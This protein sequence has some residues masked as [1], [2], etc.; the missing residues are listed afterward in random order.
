MFLT[1]ELVACLELVYE[2]LDDLEDIRIGLE[3]GQ[4]P[5]SFLAPPLDPL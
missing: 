2:I 5:A 1:M 3:T 4:D